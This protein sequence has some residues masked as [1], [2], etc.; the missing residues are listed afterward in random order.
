MIGCLHEAH[1]VEIRRA[2][3]GTCALSFLLHPEHAKRTHT[4]P[5]AGSFDPQR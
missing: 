3:T 2:P 4:C 1:V 5:A